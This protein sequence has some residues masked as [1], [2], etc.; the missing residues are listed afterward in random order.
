MSSD[1]I[2]NLGGGPSPAGRR[3]GSAGT[4]EF[5]EAQATVQL[6]DGTARTVQIEVAA[7]NFRR[8]PEGALVGALNESSADLEEA[9]EIEVEIGGETLTLRQTGW[10]IQ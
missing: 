3:G 6:A 8:A 4:G 5:L 10:E 7:H 9:E 1:E 2:E